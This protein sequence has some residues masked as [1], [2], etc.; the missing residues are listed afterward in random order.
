MQDMDTYALHRT[1]PVALGLLD[2]V[3]VSLEVLIVVGMASIRIGS[4]AYNPNSDKAH[5]GTYF[6]DLAMATSCGGLEY[7]D[8]ASP[9]VGAPQLPRT[10]G[11]TPIGW[12]KTM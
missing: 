8:A 5:V 4:S 9:A 6:L 7:S 3:T 12:L 1:C 11:K 2:T 10:R